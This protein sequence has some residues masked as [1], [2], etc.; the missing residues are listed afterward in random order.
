MRADV[1]RELDRAKLMCIFRGAKMSD[2]KLKR[3]CQAVLDGGSRLVEIT[4]NHNEE[5]A[6]ETPRSI[7]LLKEEFGA[8]LYVGSGTTLR[9]P[10]VVMA[11]EAGASFVVAPTLNK[12]VIEEAQRRDMMCM[13]GAGTA[14]EALQAHEWGA[15]YVKIFPV[16]EMGLGYAKAL[17]APLG[18]IKYF[19]VCKMTPKNY[20]E[21]LKIGYAGAGISSSINAPELIESE[22]YAEITK[23]VRVYVDIAARY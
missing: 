11:H 13:P 8:D 15:D 12:E 4:Y 5:R 7:A 6:E 20:E 19:A 17:M 9:V 2:E 1:V 23:R 10:E 14:T 18:F 21:Y 3:A 22:D 16:G